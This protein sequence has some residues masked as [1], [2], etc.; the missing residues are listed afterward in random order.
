MASRTKQL[1]LINAVGSMLFHMSLP[2]GRELLGFM[3]IVLRSSFKNPLRSPI[4]LLHNY[5]N[6]SLALTFASEFVNKLRL[7]VEHNV[8]LMLHCFFLKTVG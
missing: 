7:P 8:S 1:H 2:H 3:L 6:L 5:M 4:V